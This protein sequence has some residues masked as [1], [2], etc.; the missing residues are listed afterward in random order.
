MNEPRDPIQLYHLPRLKSPYLVAAW[1]GMGAVGLLAVNY[2]R[3]QL[4]AELFGRIDP[5]VYY[6]PTQVLIQEGIIQPVALPE[7]KLYCWDRGAEH[8]LILLVGTEQPTDAYDVA[9]QVTHIAAR[10]GVTR[11]YTAAASPTLIHHDQ[12]PGVWGTATHAE[13]LPALRD[14]GVVLMEQGTI[15]GLNGLLLAAAL[16]RGM[17]GVCLLGEIPVYTTQM[18]NPL[19]SHAVLAALTGLLEIDISV[20]RLEEWAQDLAPQ[21]DQ[22]YEMLP[23]HAREALTQGE[24]ASPFFSPLSPEGELPLV[25]DDAFFEGIERFLDDQRP[26][27]DEETDA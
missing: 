5:E 24:G 13:L 14:R 23:D 4:D 19:A 27:D 11:V 26:E 21:M 15:G 17:E 1:S 25:A 9:V 2:L 3:Q 12:S 20:D 22:L 8:D 7:T 10:L 18:I 16:Q 6:A